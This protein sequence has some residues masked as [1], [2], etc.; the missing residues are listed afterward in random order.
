VAGVRC[1][2]QQEETQD[3]REEQGGDSELADSAA[4]QH[5]GWSIML[6]VLEGG[7]GVEDGGTVGGEG[8]EDDA[9]GDRGGEGDNGGGP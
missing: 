2:Q 6:L 4:S 1:E 7:Y 5:C 8:A 3:H 9:Y